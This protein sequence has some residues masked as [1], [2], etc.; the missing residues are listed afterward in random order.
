MPELHNLRPAT[1][2]VG[3]G[4]EEFTYTH[5]VASFF[6]HLAARAGKRAFLAFEFAARQYPALVFCTLHD[7]DQRPRAPAHHDAACR[8]NGL[9][10]HIHRKSRSSRLAKLRPRMQRNAHT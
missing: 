7:S 1:C 6:D 9:A 3:E 8:M 10:R 5:A 2:S 4:A